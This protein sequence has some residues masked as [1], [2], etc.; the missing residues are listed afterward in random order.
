[1]TCGPGRLTLLHRELTRLYSTIKPSVASAGDDADGFSSH[2]ARDAIFV[3]QAKPAFVG[4]RPSR[5]GV[6]YL[7]SGGKI[8]EAI[9]ETLV[10]A[11][12]DRDC[13]S[14]VWEWFDAEFPCGVLI[15]L[16]GNAPTRAPARD[17]PARD[18]AAVATITSSRP[19]SPAE[20][21]IARAQGILSIP[22]VGDAVRTHRQRP[23]RIA[24]KLCVPPCKLFIP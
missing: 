24:R 9:R 12:S 3:D 11:R 4:A 16:T 21:A 1:M 6:T 23:G 8:R 14:R 22:G 18:V 5:T 13:D 2:A 7:R 20:R 10:A 19:P 17:G 15:R